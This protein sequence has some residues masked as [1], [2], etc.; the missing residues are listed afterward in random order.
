MKTNFVKRVIESV[1]NE[2]VKKACVRL[3][4]LLDTDA[5]EALCSDK[6]AVKIIKSP[7]ITTMHQ[8]DDFAKT[9]G[10]NITSNANKALDCE[11]GDI[12]NFRSV[13]FELNISKECIYVG[14]RYKWVEEEKEKTDYDSL[15]ISIEE[16]EKAGFEFEYV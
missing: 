7:E 14:Y 10:K 15:T 9:C 16:A 2:D 8:F 13:I 5:L 12:N 6:L 4:Y 11:V 1:I 3:A